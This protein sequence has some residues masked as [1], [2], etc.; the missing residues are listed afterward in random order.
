[1]IQATN[2]PAADPESR[3][4]PGRYGIAVGIAALVVLALIASSILNY[5]YLDSIPS[6]AS[7]YGL[8][9]V[10][11]ITLGTYILVRAFNRDRSARRKHL[12]RAGVL[13]G[14]GVLLWLLVID[15]F[16]FT[17]S[18]G[19][20][21]A[22]V[23]ALACVPTTAFGL[24]V[25]RRMDRNHK[26][27]WRLVLVAAAWGAIVATSLVVWGET[28]WESSAQHSLVPGPGLDASLAFM[29]GILE[30]LAKGL[31]VVLLYL[32]MRNEFDDIV[33]GI[34]YGAAVGLGFNFME[35]VSYMTNLY[36]I[37]APENFGGIAAGIQWYG[38]QVLG[39]F[40]GHATYTAFIGA[41]LGVARQIPGTRRKALA[42]ASGFLIAIAGHFSWD[43]WATFFPYQ[44]T[45]FG[46]VEIHLR[47]LIM[48][49]PFTAALIALLLAGIGYEGR[50][51]RDQMEKEA[52]TG[53]GA[54]LPDEVPVLASPIKRLRQRL[55]AF[56]RKGFAGYLQVSRLQTAQLDLAMERWHR[57]RK[58]TDTPF[59]AEQE[60]R[61]RVLELRHWVAAA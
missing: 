4:R 21:V 41:G 55:Q 2:P 10:A 11:L 60:L 24:F 58:E 39:L 19:P 57:E 49:G 30:E 32:V 27:P 7:L 46:L 28:V 15:V 17:Q 40:F 59:E 56:E 53:S 34:V 43:A 25:V 47:T 14:L 1:V 33:D 29:A 52:A 18:A 48:T 23:C 16:I 13:I 6:R 35:S 51:L 9:A 36:S 22:A 20:A 44:S 26:E 45:F 42:I 3:L 5:V 54:I 31:A 12:I 38:R 37:F 8:L 50:N 61:R